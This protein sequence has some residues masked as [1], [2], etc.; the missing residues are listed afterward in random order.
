[1]Y[2]SRHI[3]IS[4]DFVENNSSSLSALS[5]SFPKVL[6]HTGMMQNGNGQPMKDKHVVAVAEAI[7]YYLYR[8]PDASGTVAEIAREWIPAS[9]MVDH[10]TVLAALVQLEAQG[11]IE[12][13]LASNAL[14][15]QLKRGNGNGSSSG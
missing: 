11:F 13:S 8:W 7:R 2:A 6:M 5:F 3:P 1:V 14:I 15:W 12:R 9:G 4:A 10:D